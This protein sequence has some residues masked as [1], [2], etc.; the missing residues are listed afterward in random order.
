MYHPFVTRVAA[1]MVVR[2]ERML[3]LR[4]EVLVSTGSRVEP[5]DIV[6][7]AILPSGIQLLN[8]AK[9]LSIGN[10][11]LARHLRVN[12]GDLVAEGDV[13]AAARGPT[14]FL[15]RTFRSP[16]RG[17][18]V[19]IAK[20]RL[21]VQSSRTTVELEAHYKGTV[22]NVMSGLGAIIEAHGALVQAIWGSGE[23]GFGLLRVVVDDPA[24]SIDA[25]AIDVSC[26]DAVLV[27]GSFIGE[28]ALYR[29]QEMHVEGIVV[30]GLDAGL[31]E[32]A[33]SMPFPVIVTEGMGRFAIATPIFEEWSARKLSSMSPMR[34]GSRLWNPVPN[35]SWDSARW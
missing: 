16:I 23:E 9:A 34:P 35:S 18:V 24:Q 10:E 2:R 14:S 27:G 21:L 17:M 11:D 29:A 25:E 7:S 5:S 15:R 31:L 30:G 19:A 32:L 6:A 28:E 1:S 33:S 13:L 12:V 22:I 3:P 8:V 4:G 26:R 20:G